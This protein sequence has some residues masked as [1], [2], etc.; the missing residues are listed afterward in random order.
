MNLFKSFRS[1]VSG[2]ILGFQ[3]SFLAYRDVTGLS[4]DR[5]SIFY[6]VPSDSRLTVTQWTRGEILRK[7]H[8][9]FQTFGI[10]KEAVRGIARH[11]VGKG[12]CLQL[13]STD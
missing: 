2:A 4:A 11:S 1:A 13:N 5:G 10:V 12:I 3:T 8:W 9:L 6:Y 7:V